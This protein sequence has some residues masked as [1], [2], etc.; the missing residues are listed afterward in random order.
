M[1]AEDNEKLFSKNVN[2]LLKDYDQ[3]TQPLHITIYN[4]HTTAPGHRRELKVRLTN[5]SDLLFLQ[6]LSLSED[7]F[8]C[9]KNQQV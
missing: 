4:T 1:A 7:D 8:Q 3:K 5:A 9:L 6:T 2:V